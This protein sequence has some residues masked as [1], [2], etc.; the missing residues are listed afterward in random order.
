MKIRHMMNSSEQ[1]EDEIL[2]WPKNCLKRLVLCV[3]LSFFIVQNI[4]EVK[5]DFVKLIMFV[6]YSG[7]I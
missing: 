6:L 3:F 5:R 1:N 4:I 7:E 2:L